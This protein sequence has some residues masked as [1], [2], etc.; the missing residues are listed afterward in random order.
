[1]GEPMKLGAPVRL[2]LYTE[3]YKSLASRQRHAASRLLRG[4]RKQMLPSDS[5]RIPPGSV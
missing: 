3:V 2:D 5:V 4:S 1:M